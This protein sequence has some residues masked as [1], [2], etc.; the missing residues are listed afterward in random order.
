MRLPSRSR[1]GALLVAVAALLA[2][3]S[4][5]V[6]AQTR[7]SGQ[8][9]LVGI[10]NR[11]SLG[12]NSALRGDNPF[13][14]VRL[15][16]FVQ[17][18]VTER[19]GVF[20]ELLYDID[21]DP[22]MNGAYVVV[23]EIAGRPWLNARLGLAP[24]LVGSFALRSTYFNANPLVGIPLLWQ[25]RTNLRSDGTSTAASLATS[26][27]EPAGGVPML[28]DAC[29]NVQWELLGELGAF[30][31][32]VGIT[33]GSVSNPV[34]SSG[35]GGSQWLGRLGVSPLTGLRA[36]VSAAHG[37]YLSAPTPGAG[38]VLPYAGDP[39]SYAQSALGADLEY[40]RGAWIFHSELFGLRYETPLVPER[41]QAAGAYVEARYDFRPGW[42]FA[43]RVGGLFFGDVVT[44]APS[45]VSGPWD[46]DTRRTEV[47]LG[48]RMSREVL[49]KLDWQRTTTVD[50]DFELNLL[51]VQLSAVF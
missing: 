35:V 14:S 18:W 19:I 40:Q 26:T 32:S 27:A 48:Y 47:A 43:G 20:A 44:D 51:A 6:D 38:G 24:S 16:L 49:V 30:E 28:Y 13:H 31:Y 17:S 12:L 15:K 2:G 46:Q 34:R 50:A 42:Y 22:R 41:L 4:H 25:Y 10:A 29:W 8:L 3:T 11:D 39:S 36:G 21:A 5:R 1:L 45:G 37:P 7:I 33:P 23:N 9:D